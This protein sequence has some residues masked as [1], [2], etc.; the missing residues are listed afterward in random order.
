MQRLTIHQKEKKIK[1]KAYTT[2]EVEMILR[3]KRT[4]SDNKDTDLNMLQYEDQPETSIKEKMSSAVV[5]SHT[6]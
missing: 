3:A 5:Y 6:G 2:G 4:A 1:R